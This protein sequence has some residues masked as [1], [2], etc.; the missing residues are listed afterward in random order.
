MGRKSRPAKRKTKRSLPREAAERMGAERR[1]IEEALRES[2]QMF[3]ATFDQAAVGI[4]LVSLDLRYLRVNDK[5]C[6]IVGYS[7]DELRSMG[8]RDTNAQVGLGEATDFLARL[9]AGE[10]AGHQLRERELVRKDG[11]KVWVAIAAS[12]VRGASGEAPYFVSVIQDISEAKRAA[13]ALRES[14]ERFRRTFELAGSGVAHIG[15]D[16]RFLLVN[17]RLCEILGYSEDELMRLT[18]RQIS[19]PDDLDLINA[20]RPRLYAGEIDAVR[21]EKR[22]LRKDGSVIWVALTMVV[23]RDAAGEPQYEIA[24]F[25]DITSRKQAEVAL[26]ESEERFRQLAH[27][28]TLTKLPNRALFYDRLRQTLAL[29][30]RKSWTVGVMFIDL[31]RFKHVNDTLGHAAGDKLLLQVAERL[32]KSVR[33]SDTV[34]RLGGD[35]F[36]VVL[37]SVTASGDAA[38][39]AQKIIAAFQEPIQVEGHAIAA[40]VSVGVALYPDDSTDQDA[41]IKY[42]DAAMY[43]SKEA[44]RN[45]FRLFSAAGSP[46]SRP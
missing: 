45:C 19:H 16:R 41:L 18:G 37:S 23:E 39:V 4:T 3:R 46:D 17:R 8:L 42:A 7:Q 10:V 30:K 22:Y 20:Q 11:S 13:A 26:R 14:E 44:G 35:E 43:R 5:F 29:A 21:V 9:A 24:V 36:A 1:R 34:A 33:A 28:D 15:M 27:Y 38:V 25:D 12:L 31:D 32:S 40:T 6:E 2:E